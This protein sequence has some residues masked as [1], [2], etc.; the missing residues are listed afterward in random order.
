MSNNIPIIETEFSQD[1]FDESSKAWRKN[2][3][4][5]SNGLFEYKCCFVDSNKKR[6]TR[7]LYRDECSKSKN[8]LNKNNRD[9]FCKLHINKKYIEKDHLWN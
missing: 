6:C 4:V 3:R 1:F 7:K 8:I 9:I 5:K 2:K